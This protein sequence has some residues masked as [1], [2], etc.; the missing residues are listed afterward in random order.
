MSLY[1][2]SVII[3]MVKHE[4]G[5]IQPTKVINHDKVVIILHCQSRVDQLQQY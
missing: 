4:Y 5:F 2:D 1:S 3:N